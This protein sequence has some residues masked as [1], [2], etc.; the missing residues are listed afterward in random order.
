MKNASVLA[1]YSEKNLSYLSRAVEPERHLRLL[2]AASE[3]L[4]AILELRGQH[5]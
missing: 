1:G 2:E 4:E 3:G 5:T